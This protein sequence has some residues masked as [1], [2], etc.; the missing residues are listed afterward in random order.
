[1]LERTPHSIVLIEGRKESV[2]QSSPHVRGGTSQRDQIKNL[3]AV[4]NRLSAEVCPVVYTDG[5]EHLAVI[6]KH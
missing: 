3:Q 5:K 1:M 6:S 2:Y 4:L